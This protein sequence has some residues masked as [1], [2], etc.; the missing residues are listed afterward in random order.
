M[1]TVSCLGRILVIEDNRDAADTLRVML[2]MAGYEVRVAYDGPEGVAAADAWR[3]NLVFCDIGLPGMDGYAVADELH[4]RDVVPTALL[5]A[6]TG[7]GSREDRERCGEHG[8]TAH[9]SKPAEPAELLELL[10][11]V[12]GLWSPVEGL[13]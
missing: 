10:E 2:E 9:L 7:Y 13:A 8:F 3:P 6:V 11:H 12:R 5:I 4:R 1:T